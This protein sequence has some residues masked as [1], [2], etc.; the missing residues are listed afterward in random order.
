MP[1]LVQAQE[2]CE[3]GHGHQESPPGAECVTCDREQ[4]LPLA[5][6]TMKPQMT[7]AQP[8]AM[9]STGEW[10]RRKKHHSRKKSAENEWQQPEGKKI[11]FSSRVP[12][13]WIWGFAALLIVAVLI[14]ALALQQQIK[15]PVPTLVPSV[16]AQLPAIDVKKVNENKEAMLQLSQIK[17]A[18]ELIE[19]FFQARTIEDLMPLLRPVNGL[20]EKIRRYYS[21]HPLPDDHY[22]G[23]EK[24]ASTLFAGGRGLET[25]I[26]VKNQSMKTITLIKSGDRF[27]IDWESWVGWSE[28]NVSSL[29]DKKPMTPVEVRVTVEVESYYN[30]DFPSSMEPRWQ[31]YKLI[32]A[33]DGQI[34]HAYVE[35]SSP[36]H[37][38]VTPPSDVTS[39]PMTLRIRYRDEESHSSQVLID[40]V[41]AEGWVKERPRE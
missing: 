28:M 22:D 40:S 41:V 16:A 33:D 23:I 1:A 10:R 20:E 35:R 14:I 25:L 15:D 32:F 26:R 6:Q 3:I 7:P 36:L 12:L 9:T 18:H 31:S 37:Q 30:Y 24:Q 11:R 21:I 4:P 5:H 17:N 19:D 34:L 39:W 27:Q 13:V 8:E 29:R 38:L 2:V